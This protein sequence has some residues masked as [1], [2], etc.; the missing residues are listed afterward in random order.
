M[1]DDLEVLEMELDTMQDKV[2][3]TQFSTKAG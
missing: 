1:V 3:L 2:R